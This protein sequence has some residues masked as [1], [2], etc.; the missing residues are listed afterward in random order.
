[1]VVHGLGP[2]MWGADDQRDERRARL[3]QRPRAGKVRAKGGK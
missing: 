3:A 1:L 2:K